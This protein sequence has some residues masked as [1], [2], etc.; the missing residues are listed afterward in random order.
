MGKKILVTV[1]SWLLTL[2]V[3][4]Q[5]DLYVSV[6]QEGTLKETIELIADD[7][8]NTVSSMKVN[9]PIN[10]TDMMFIREMCGVK[11]LDT[12]TGGQL[13]VLN[14]TNANVVASPEVYLS[15]Y[16]VDF[17]T[18]ENHF[19]S[20]FLY[21]CSQLEE[22]Y[23]PMEAVSIDTLALAMCSSLKEVMI[24]S[25]VERIGYGAFYGCSSIKSMDVPD[26]VSE[27]EEGAFQNMN[28]LEE[29]F[30]GNAVTSLDNSAIMGDDSLQGITLGEG[31]KYYSPVLFCNSPS[32]ANI[33]VTPGN[34]YYSSWEGVLF[35]SERDSLLVYPPA[36]QTTE[37]EIPEGVSRISPYAFCMASGL[38][39]VIMPS[40]MQVIDTLAFYGCQ[41]LADV[42]LNEGLRTLKF[43][44]FAHLV[45]EESSLA[46]LSLPSTVDEIEGGAF[47]FQTALLNVSE[48]NEH[49]MTD[50]AGI[51]FNKAG[52]VLCH[53]P[54]TISQA[55]LAQT[56]DSVAPYAF[57]GTSLASIYLGD[58][59]RAIG[60]GAFFCANAYQ[61]TLGRGVERLG[62][63]LVDGCSQLQALYCYA[64]PEDAQVAP[65]AFWDKGGEV[66]RQCVLYVLPGKMSEYMLKRGF[67]STEG[68]SYFS[69]IQEMEDADHIEVMRSEIIP[70]S[71]TYDWNGRRVS[72]SHRGA[73]I[74]ILPDGKG[75]KV[76]GN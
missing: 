76:I 17:T 33:N 24:P 63:L 1:F 73:R 21:N 50:G 28:A 2:Q 57:A 45:G 9:G 18:Q 60:N 6:F 12:P 51:L 53:M 22:I 16:G 11:D 20:G 34:P 70:G 47:L 58:G 61:I 7:A 35:S 39:T 15:M 36:Y 44:A 31:F 55:E 72:S 3:M 74:V 48:Q 69:A 10:G 41:S 62:D 32:L 40:T 67:A 54:C 38:K 27:I 75:I 66:A 26:M 23:L 19:G 59:V 5:Y 4:A 29:L 71:P 8:M 37:Y 43:G 65:T 14:L 25:G 46:T 64:S 42:R 13:R 30:L 52:T 56:I 49:Y 68:K